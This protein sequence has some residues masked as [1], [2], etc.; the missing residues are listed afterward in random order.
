MSNTHRLNKWMV[1]F[2]LQHA[3]ALDDDEEDENLDH[4]WSPPVCNTESHANHERSMSRLI[5][6]SRVAKSIIMDLQMR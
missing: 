2:L 5:E 4:L 1:K 3:L 6:R